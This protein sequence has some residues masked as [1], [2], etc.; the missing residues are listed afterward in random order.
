MIC[1]IYFILGN[2]R[3]S[4]PTIYLFPGGQGDCALFG[5][6]GFNL[7]VNGGYSKQ[8][9]FWD[10]TRHLDRIDALMQTHIGADNLFGMSSF[11]ERKAEENVAPELGCVLINAPP[12]R[13]LNNNGTED[14]INVADLS[15]GVSITG[16]A[17]K[18]LRNLNTFKMTPTPCTGLG[19]ASGGLNPMNLYHKVGHGT[20]DV[21]VLNPPAGGDKE[22]K[23]FFAQWKKDAPAFTSSKSI[24]TPNMMSICALLVWKPASETEPITRLDNS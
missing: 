19:P 17:N 7:L 18:M 8:P 1:F 3:F 22:M 24:P 5:I 2:I 23:E 12:C 13:P 10:F 21:Y 4:G 6:A 20:L 14:A 9:C 15:L 16:E 11:I